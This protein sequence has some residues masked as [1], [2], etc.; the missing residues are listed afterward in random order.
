M[1]DVRALLLTDVVDSTKLSESLGDAAMAQVWAGH[2]RVARDLLPPWRGREIDKTDG[3]LLLFDTAADAIGYATQYHLALA[4]LPLPLVARAGLHVGAVILRENSADDVAR[5]AKPLEV[6]GLAKPTAARVMSLARGGQTLLTVE[7]RDDLGQTELKLH[8]H[9]H[10]LVKGVAEP[11][12]L[13]EAGAAGTRF[14]APADSD[15]VHRVVRVGEWW[16]PVKDIANNLPHQGT[17]F[18]GRE[19]ELDQVTDL[20]AAT[21]LV[22]LLG[23]GGLGKTRLSLELAAL[24]MHRF[25]DGV[26]FLDLAPLRDEAL[27]ASEAARVLDVSEEPGRPLLQS[28]CA[29]LKT[30]RVLIIIDNCEHLIKACAELAHALVRQAPHVRMLASSRE[31]LHVPGER[32]Y[33]ILPLPLPVAQRQLRGAVAIGSGASVRR[34]RPGTQAHLQP[35]AGGAGGGRAGG[36]TRRHPAGAGTGGG[37]C[38]LAA[39]VRHQPAP[40]GSLQA[41]HRRQ[42]CAATAPT[43]AARA[44]R[45]VLRAADAR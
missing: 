45:L 5:G 4:A 6:D 37:A 12:E 17:S 42:P 8:S 33:P 1:S 15:K 28:L 40:E 22:T 23:M 10:W 31:P 27:V 7:A 35:A 26:W 29:H 38:A 14:V 13:F 25:P 44:G 11:L 9:G 18:I 32:S 36:A 21:R 24:Q 20:L 3:M 16:M 39:G 30:R 41:A 43:D 19:T 34:T 2:D